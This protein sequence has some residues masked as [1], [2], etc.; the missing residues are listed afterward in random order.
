MYKLGVLFLFDYDRL[1]ELIKETG[2]TK[3]SIADRIGRKPSIFQAWRDKKS[4]PSVDQIK[5]VAEILHTTP[6]YLL[7]QTNEKTPTTQSDGGSEVKL[8][9]LTNYVVTVMHDL[10]IEGKI[11][12]AN[13][14]QSLKAERQVQDIQKESV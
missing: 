1:E 10:P 13:Y 9:D 12:L 4:M 11:L 7:G 6:D 2:I 8:D 5:I 3:K 14:A